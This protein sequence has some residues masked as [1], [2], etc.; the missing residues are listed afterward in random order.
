MILPRLLFALAAMMVL[1]SKVAAD[2]TL[3]GTAW[4]NGSTTAISPNPGTVGHWVPTNQGNITGLTF[5]PGVR[6]QFGSNSGMVYLQNLILPNS[7]ATGG[8]ATYVTVIDLAT[9]LVVGSSLNQVG[10]GQDTS[11]TTATP[12]R[13][14]SLALDSSGSYALVFTST[15]GTAGLLV[16]GV[17]GSTGLQLATGTDLDPSAGGTLNVATARWG[18]VVN[19]GV[20]GTDL[21]PGTGV[22]TPGVP[23]P[24]Q[25]VNYEQWY[26]ATFTSTEQHLTT[27][28]APTG[29]TITQASAFGAAGGFRKTGGGTYVLNQANTSSGDVIVEQGTLRLVLAANGTTSSRVGGTGATIMLNNYGAQLQS[30]NEFSGATLQLEFGG[31][32]SALA[33]ADNNIEGVGT[34]RKTGTGQVSMTGTNGFRG[35]L[36]IESGTVAF[37]SAGAAAGEFHVQIT[38][39]AA[40]LALGEYFVDKVAVIASLSGTGAVR[41]NFGNTGAVNQLKTL[42]VRQDIDTEFS[43]VFQNN[44]G[45]NLAVI[46]SGAGIL[47]FSGANVYQGTTKVN[48]GWLVIN[49]DQSGATGAVTVNAG[50]SLGGVGQVGGLTTVASGGR[51]AAG[52]YG[53]ANTIGT[54]SLKAG[55]VLQTGSEVVFELSGATGTTAD[56]LTIAPGVLNGTPGN[57]DHLEITGSLALGDGAVVKVV[58]KDYTASWGDVFNLADWSAAGGAINQGFDP[59]VDMDFTGAQLASG[60]Y[61]AT[62]RF[63]SDG[64]IY[65]APEPSRWLLLMM[66]VL[67]CA[68]IRRR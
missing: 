54:L 51:L 10:A 38:D 20:S 28:D 55:L 26:T 39:A 27:L 8:S 64:V 21:M 22:Y 7:P 19:T 57:H 58:L 66:A 5:T 23:T 59:L 15:P 40:S 11:L 43:G 61:W 12:Y 48:G 4:Y 29:Q 25:Y 35:N 36:V 63:L 1:S 14:D 24:G 41:A 62:D 3:A 67:A 42:E 17:P 50:G 6:N 52:D 32:G 49:G 68:C 33:I 30:S 31:G 44:G 60:W 18:G 9:H 13:F 56:L 46:K 34:I 53:A 45:R 37:N 2:V 47:K 16:S 65:V